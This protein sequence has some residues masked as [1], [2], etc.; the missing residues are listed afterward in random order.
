MIS[1]LRNISEGAGPTT[2]RITDA[3]ILQT[4]MLMQFRVQTLVCVTKPQP[5]G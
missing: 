4:A 1:S 2:T 5:K 3:T